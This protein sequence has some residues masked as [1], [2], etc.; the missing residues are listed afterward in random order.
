MMCTKE[1]KQD[2]SKHQQG[3]FQ[4][5][6]LKGFK[7]GTQWFSAGLSSIGLTVGLDLM[8]LFQP[9]LFYNSMILYFLKIK[10]NPES[11]EKTLQ[12]N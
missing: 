7:G 5:L 11:S 4:S 12:N 3:V 1:V 9:K 6:S 10:K 2:H 8:G